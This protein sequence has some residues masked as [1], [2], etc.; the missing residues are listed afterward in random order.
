MTTQILVAV[1]TTTVVG[2]AAS[3]LGFS[4]YSLWS[5]FSE[6][7]APGSSSTGDHTDQQRDGGHHHVGRRARSLKREDED[8][9]RTRQKQEVLVSATASTSSSSSVPR[10]G[11]GFGKGSLPEAV[12]SRAAPSA[13][14]EEEV[15]VYPDHDSTA[16]AFD[17][18]SDAGVAAGGG[19]SPQ[20]GI[21]VA[22]SVTAA[23][24]RT[25][26]K[27]TAAN[28]P[29][30]RKDEGLPPRAVVMSSSAGSGDA[31]A[32]GAFPPADTHQEVHLHAAT[33]SSPIKT[34]FSDN[35]VSIL[36][37]RT[38]SSS[39]PKAK[40]RGED[41]DKNPSEARASMS[42]AIGRGGSSGTSSADDV[43]HDEWSDE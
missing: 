31:G 32:V 33:P 12:F 25:S 29:A 1:G 22:R 26:S 39:P 43:G 34:K 6:K 20:S 3:A 11:T 14:V 19:E 13:E 2:T 28:A 16:R 15:K 36:R 27:S 30:P 38:P 41:N 17:T 4:A 21:A 42:T 37:A 9:A 8:H 40:R 35:I 24:P 18:D 23:A 5:W 10:R 7:F